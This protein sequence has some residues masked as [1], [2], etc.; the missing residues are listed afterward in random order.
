MN[1]RQIFDLIKRSTVAIAAI[2]KREAEHPFTIV[3]SGFCIDPVGLIVTCR[4]V[5]EALMEKTA[6]Q[7]IAEVPLEEKDKP[8]QKLGPVQAITPFAVFYVTKASREKLF[9]FPC[10]IDNVVAKTDFDLALMRVQPHK[11]FPS[12]YPSLQ[13]EEYE[14]VTEGDEVGTCGFPLG[15]YLHDQLGTVTSS[16]T[17]GVISSIIPSAGTAKEFLKGFQLGLTAT[18]GNSG[19]PVFSLESGKVFGVLQCGVQDASG[20]LLSGITKAE[21]VYPMLALDLIARMK[22]TPFGVPL[23]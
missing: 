12:G 21:P 19:G 5:V 8:I 17:T 2:N 1:R 20:G 14:T 16:F 22:T 4:H 18:H 7:Q 3:G 11:A 23:P 13:I 9:A 15:N 6:E 10:Q